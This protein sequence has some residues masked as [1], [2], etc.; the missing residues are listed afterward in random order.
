M[1]DLIDKTTD[2][3]IDVCYRDYAETARPKAYLVVGQPG[4][5][6]TQI[7]REICKEKD[8]A[9]ING[10]GFRK[11]YPEYHELYRKHGDE[12][13]NI[14]KGFS[15][16]ITE[17]L[18]EKLS[19]KRLDLIIEGTLRTTD[20]PEKTRALLSQKGY[21]TELDL[22]VVKPE[23]SWLRT[24]RRYEEMKKEGMTPRM[25]PKDH[26]DKVVKSLQIGRASCREIV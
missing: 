20:V 16:A 11:F 4:A 3:L 1:N 24:R 18:I 23:I 19:D 5:G 14:T 12:L 10:D 2:V 22:I 17:R 9:Y 21:K 25:T 13:V 8:I 26:H 7:I 15:G 6:K